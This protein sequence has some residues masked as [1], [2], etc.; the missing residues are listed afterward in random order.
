[1]SAACAVSSSSA[2][3][4]VRWPRERPE[5][6]SVGRMLGLLA[7]I[8]VLPLLP[9]DPGTDLVALLAPALPLLLL[10]KQDSK[11]VRGCQ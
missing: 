5:Q 7:L 1:M 4:A 2:F 10:P 3:R 6:L 9:F 8:L 11:Q